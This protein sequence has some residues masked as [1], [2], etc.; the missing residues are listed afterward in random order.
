MNSKRPDVC[1]EFVSSISNQPMETAAQFYAQS[2]PENEKAS[3]YLRNE[4]RYSLEQAA[5]H[6]IGFSDRSLGRLLPTGSSQ[7]G[8]AL[9]QKL[10]AI[11][12]FKP[13][14]HET[15]RLPEQIVELPVIEVTTV[16]PWEFAPEALIRTTIRTSSR[17]PT[18][19]LLKPSRTC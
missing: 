3:A 19:P 11:G 18:R 8:R 5:E 4:L 6:L 10:T 1:E 17:I 7:R 2:L 13:S 14:G 12:L 16:P 15:L 9:R